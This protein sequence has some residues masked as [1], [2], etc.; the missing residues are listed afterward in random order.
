MAVGRQVTRPFGVRWPDVAG[1]QDDP[2]RVVVAEAEDRLGEVVGDSDVSTCSGGR[3]ML[4]ATLM[5]AQSPGCDFDVRVARVDDAC[6]GDRPALVADL[7]RRDRAR[8][9][10]VACPAERDD[11]VL[12]GDEVAV[13]EIAGGA[14]AASCRSCRRR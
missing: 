14:V 5:I 4:S 8:L 11:A 9:A 2:L 12:D 1:A 10:A 6:A 7:D 13:A 3:S